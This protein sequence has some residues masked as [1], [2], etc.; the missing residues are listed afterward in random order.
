EKP[1]VLAFNKADSITDAGP[2]ETLQTM[3]PEA[4]TISARTGLGLGELA[5]KVIE[6]YRGREIVLRITTSQGN[7]KIQSFL[8]TYGQLLREQYDDGVVII[9]VRMG[10]NQIPELERLRPE[11]LEVIQG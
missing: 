9:E 6:H 11:K 4:V 3:Y 7:G 2:L 5:R 1:I 8:R 10:K